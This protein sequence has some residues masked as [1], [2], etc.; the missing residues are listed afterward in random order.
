MDPRVA[1]AR[2][3]AQSATAAAHTSHPCTPDV[4]ADRRY[5][6]VLDHYAKR[7]MHT[8]ICGINV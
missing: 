8:P 4:I 5:T 7:E 1:R 6:P 2:A 3:C